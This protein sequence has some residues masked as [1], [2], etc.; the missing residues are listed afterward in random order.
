MCN[1]FQ[2]LNKT[3]E[4]V[5][6]AWR[7]KSTYWSQGLACFKSRDSC[8]TVKLYMESV[9]LFDFRT[10]YSFVLYLVLLVLMSFGGKGCGLEFYVFL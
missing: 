9:S 7:S 4:G 3:R 2:E 5:A 10:K 1:N 6:S 8:I